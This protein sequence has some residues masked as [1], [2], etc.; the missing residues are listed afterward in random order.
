MFGVYWDFVNWFFE[1]FK[2]CYY[3][4]NIDLYI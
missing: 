1:Y 2:F 3:Y 4:N